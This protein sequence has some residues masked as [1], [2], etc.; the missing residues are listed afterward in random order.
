MQNEHVLAFHHPKP[1]WET[2]LL[3]V[4][5]NIV[6]TLI[7]VDVDDLNQVE[8]L[9]QLLMA[10]ERAAFLCELGSYSILVNGGKYQDVPQ[11]H[12]HVAGGA[13]EQG[14]LFELEELNEGESVVE[15]HWD[16]HQ[17]PVV[18]G[19][20]RTLFVAQNPFGFE[21]GSAEVAEL[22]QLVKRFV[23]E[24]NFAGF[25]V[26]IVRNIGGLETKMIVILAGELVG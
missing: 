26:R 1:F 3:V 20:Y 13:N 15:E 19:R 18:N 8:M 14:N 22:F 9:Q 21:T 24:V 6:P 17:K 23:S 12:F 10:A 5:K 4:P 16:V 2:H 25:S 11:L 7:S